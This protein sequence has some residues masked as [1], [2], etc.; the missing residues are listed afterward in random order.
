MLPNPSYKLELDFMVVTLFH[1][2][3]KYTLNTNAKKTM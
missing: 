3:A 2:N 1:V